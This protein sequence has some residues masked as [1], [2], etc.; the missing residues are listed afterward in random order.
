MQRT[1][2]YASFLIFARHTRRRRMLSMQIAKIVNCAFTM[3]T[4]RMWW[5]KFMFNM[6]R[7]LY[8][9]V[10]FNFMSTSRIA[11]FSKE[12]NW[13]RR[14]FIRHPTYLVLMIPLGVSLNSIRGWTL[15]I[16]VLKFQWMKD[17][18]MMMPKV[19]A[20][21]HGMNPVNPGRCRIYT[22]Q[23]LTTVVWTDKLLTAYSSMST[24][25]VTLSSWTTVLFLKMFS[26]STTYLEQ[27]HNGQ[28]VSIQN[29]THFLNFDIFNS[30]FKAKV[31]NLAG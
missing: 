14:A 17:T 13:R 5:L 18:K 22:F 7:L 26:K 21:G 10:S 30:L 12:Y 28:I 15:C 20:E 31:A 9:T 29:K 8:V 24:P 3:I 27:Q 16:L 19:S 4:V 2:K 23:R 11:H 6:S 25:C 1:L